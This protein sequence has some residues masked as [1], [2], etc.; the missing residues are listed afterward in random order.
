MTLNF[1]R[2]IQ[3]FMNDNKAI[4]YCLRKAKKMYISLLRQH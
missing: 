1:V 2:T 3:L 4:Y